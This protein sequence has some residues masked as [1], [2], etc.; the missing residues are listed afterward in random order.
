MS[1]IMASLLPEFWTNCILLAVWP[2]LNRKSVPPPKKAELLK[3]RDVE[4]FTLP[5]LT[6]RP[7][8]TLIVDAFRVEGIP[9]LPGGGYGALFIED[10]LVILGICAVTAVIPVTPRLFVL[11]F[12]MTAVFALIEFPL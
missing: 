5:L 9:E 2:S 7:P 3:P 8:F 12:V 6:T 4:I 10:T 1:M 11:M